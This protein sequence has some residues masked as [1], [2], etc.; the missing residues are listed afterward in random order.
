MS[1]NAQLY[2][3]SSCL[4]STTHGHNVNESKS[5]PLHPS[6]LFLARYTVPLIV[7]NCPGL[8]SL[9]TI[10]YPSL[11]ELEFHLDSILY[12]S[13]LLRIP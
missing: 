4:L 8:I 9:I 6:L 5:H 12:V 13:H 1:D 3:G 11:V 7:A 10:V 2:F